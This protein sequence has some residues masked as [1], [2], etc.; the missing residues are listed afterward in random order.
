MFRS[1]IEKSTRLTKGMV[2]LMAAIIPSATA[3]AATASPAPKAD[4][5][6]VT[7]TI[8]VCGDSTVASYPENDPNKL[9]R[10][11][12]Q[13]L[14]EHFQD[15]VKVIN[16]AS[17]G[18]SSKSFL[19]QPAKFQKAMELKPQ[20]VFMQFGHNDGRGK[21]PN[22]ETDPNTTYSE[23]L[24][25]MI[26]KAH[27]I[28]AECILVTPM[29]RRGFDKNGKINTGLLGPY[30]AATKRVGKEKG[31]LVIDLHDK[32]VALYEKLGK[33][34]AQDE[35]AHGMNDGTHFGEKGAK[36]WADIICQELASAGPKYDALKNAI[37]KPVPAAGSPVGREK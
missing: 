30:S 28:G 9:G 36:I 37:K 20:F 6:S 21:G 33:A 4:S 25:V 16:L 17:G 1:W 29:E 10:G 26:D 12:G 31:V 34:A 27:A 3:S 5:A 35:F 15:Y 18:Q 7:I 24:R 8:A 32:S 11:W 22:R 14:A 2:I 13:M 19:D 23:N